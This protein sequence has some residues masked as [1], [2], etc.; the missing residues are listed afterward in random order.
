MPVLRAIVRFVVTIAVVIYTLLDE[1]VFPL[2]RPLLHWLGELRLFQ[3]LGILIASL[4]PYLVLLL[5][6][7]PFVVIEPAKVYALYLG[8]TGHVVEG[9]ILLLVAQVVSLLTCERIYHVGHA[10]LMQIGWFK[11]LMD[12]IFALRD[13]ALAWAKSTALWQSSARLVRSV[14]DWLRGLLASLR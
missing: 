9:I 10:K 5:L 11:R 3:R 6:A 7:V 14:R 4:P 13:K 2:V 1:L 8:A 12:W